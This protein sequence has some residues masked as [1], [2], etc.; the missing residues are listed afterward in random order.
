MKFKSHFKLEF[1]IQTDADNM[2]QILKTICDT[3]AEKLVND[4]N[5]PTE[6]DAKCTFLKID[7]DERRT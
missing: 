7:T 5:D 4:V 3:M 6:V 2:E 1:D